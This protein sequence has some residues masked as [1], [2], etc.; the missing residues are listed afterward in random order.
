MGVKDVGGGNS[1]EQSER[2]VCL[3]A[4]LSIRNW[5][6]EEDDMFAETE[7]YSWDGLNQ[8]WT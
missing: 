7:A 2:K 5:I 4:Y 8:L 3:L 1:G 6:F